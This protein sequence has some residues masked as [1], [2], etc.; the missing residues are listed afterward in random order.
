MGSSEVQVLEEASSDDHITGWSASR[1]VSRICSLTGVFCMDAAE[2]WEPDEA[3]VSRPVLR[4]RGGEIPP[5]HSPRGPVPDPRRGRSRSRRRSRL[6]QRNCLRLHPHK[7]HLGDCRT[8][9]G[10]ASTSSA[11]ASRPASVFVRKKSLTT[12]QG[13]Y[14]G[15][16]ETHTRRQPRVHRRS[17]SIRTAARLVRLLQAR[18]SRHLLQRSTSSSADGYAPLLRKQ[19]KRSG[20]GLIRPITNAGPTPSSL[21]PGCSHFTQPG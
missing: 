16:D 5:R 1:V 17:I 10:R 15:E 19:E 7:T 20:Y 11:T 2:Q 9:R 21:K 8:R 12:P 13:S 14:P 6:R 18:P 4:E 3:R